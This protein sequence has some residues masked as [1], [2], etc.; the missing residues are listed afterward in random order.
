VL[1]RRNYLV[2]NLI[3]RLTSLEN[4]YRPFLPP[5]EPYAL[6]ELADTN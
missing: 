1:L 2:E 4:P 6:E 5:P 3:R